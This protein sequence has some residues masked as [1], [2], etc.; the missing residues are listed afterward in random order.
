MQN[1]ICPEYFSFQISSLLLEPEPGVPGQR[2]AGGAGA[3]EQAGGGAA[4]QR[5][6]GRLQLRA[7]WGSAAG[8]QLATYHR[9]AN[10]NNHSWA[11]LPLI[12]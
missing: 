4:P 11:Q 8:I 10:N 5:R 7:V 12:R 9:L 1:R 2:D 6:P 3:G